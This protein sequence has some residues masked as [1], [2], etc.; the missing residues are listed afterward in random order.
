LRLPFVHRAAG[1]AL[2]PMKKI[3]FI[4]SAAALL[5]FVAVNARAT[6][7]V[8]QPTVTV[9]STWVISDG[10]AV[11]TE[12]HQTAGYLSAQITTYDANGS[13]VDSKLFTPTDAVFGNTAYVNLLA[14]GKWLYE[15]SKDGVTYYDVG[16][17]QE[18]ANG[19]LPMLDGGPGMFI[20]VGIAAQSGSPEVWAR[21]TLQGV[22]VPAPAIAPAVVKQLTNNVAALQANVA[23][24]KIDV[25]ALKKKAGLK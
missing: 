17:M 11:R 6:I 1:V 5:T 13:V 9:P 25:A 3:T 16:G 14:P 4:L 22:P 21:A 20:Q 23:S 15:S 8:A 10:R 7:T 18:D 12:S 24:L 19:N 2:K